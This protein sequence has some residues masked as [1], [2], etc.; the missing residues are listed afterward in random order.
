MFTS[1]DD[2]FLSFPIHEK[3][4]GFF[5]GWGSKLPTTFFI[6]CNLFCLKKRKGNH[7]RR[8]WLQET[9]QNK[10]HDIEKQKQFSSCFCH[11]SFPAKFRHFS[12][13]SKRSSIGL[14]TIFFNNLSSSCQT[15]V[16]HKKKNQ[17]FSGLPY[18]LFLFIKVDSYLLFFV[19]RPTVCLRKL[20]KR[21]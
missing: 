9:R 5:W 1:L 12:E 3:L 7:K 11:L 20:Q 16:T 13:Q 15:F 21:I 17:Q 4:K 8:T 14:T 19:L 2:V 6:F 10:T 18:F